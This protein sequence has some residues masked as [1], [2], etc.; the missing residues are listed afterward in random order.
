MT[1]YI[2]TNGHHVIL[3]HLLVYA[4]VCPIINNNI[5]ENGKKWWELLYNTF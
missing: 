4:N 5:Y 2:V 3:S 1:T